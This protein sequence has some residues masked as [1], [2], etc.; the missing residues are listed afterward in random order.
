MIGIK[1][2]IV[3]CFGML[4]LFIGGILIDLDHGGDWK[5]ALVSIK[6]S[7]YAKSFKKGGDK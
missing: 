7:T 6:S 2:A 5:F 3:I 1:H 4:G